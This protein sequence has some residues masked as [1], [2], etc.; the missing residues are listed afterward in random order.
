MP[1]V[2]PAVI[3]FAGAFLVADLATGLII[4]GLTLGLGFLS[5]AL[6]PKTKKSRS[7]P[8]S[9]TAR[10]RTTTIRS[11]VEHHR[12]I[13]GQSMVSG[14]II[15]AFSTGNKNEFLHLVIALSGHQVEEIGDIFFN[16]TLSTDSRFSGLQRVNKNLG[17]EEQAADADLLSEV[18]EW[19][20][21]HQL[22]GIAYI[23]VRL[24]WDQN[25]WVTGIPNI[26]AVVKGKKV[27]DTRV[28]T[29]AITSSSVAN[30]TVITTGAVHSLSVGDQVYITGHS[31]SVPTI[32][33]EYEVITV[34][35]TTTFTIRVNVTTG[36]TGGTMSKMAWTPNASLVALDY[37]TGPFGI[38]APSA[39]VDTTSWTAA[40]NVSEEQVTLAD[41]ADTF[42]ADPATEELTITN[43]TV[44]L[45]LGDIVQ[46]S[47]TDTLPA[48]LS[49][50]T[51]Y[52]V[53][54]VRRLTTTY[55]FQLAT[56]FADSITATAI[57]I[58]DTGTGTHTVTR[59]SQARYMADGVVFTDARPVDIMD[60]L[61]T[62]SAGVMVYQ[63][64]TYR[65]YA[66]SFVAASVTLDEDD[67]RRDLQVATK[68]SRQDTFNAVRGVFV[69]QL[70]FWQAKD[71]PPVTNSTYETEDGRR[72]FKDIE[73]PHTTDIVRAQR[74]AKIALER[75]RQPISVEYPGQL[76]LLELATWDTINLTI[77]KLGWASK[78][79]R[80]LTWGLGDDGGIDLTLQEEAST[81]YDWA[82]G[83]E[84][85][86]DPAPNTT[87]TNPFTVDAP[88]NVT[89]AS[90]SANFFIAIDGTLVHRIRVTWTLPTD[91]FVTNGGN[92]EIQF[93]KTA[94][95]NFEVR[96]LIP[97]DQNFDFIGPVR[98]GDQ[99]DIKVRFINALR[100]KSAFSSTIQHTVISKT[101]A[102]DDVTQFTA[103]QNAEVVNFRWAQVTNDDLAGYEIRF[104]I[105][106]QSTYFSAT[107]LTKVTRGTAVTNAMV[108]AGDWTFYIKAVDTTGNQSI[109]AASADAVI[110]STFTAISQQEQA[111]N[112]I[113]DFTIPLS[114]ADVAVLQLI[115]NGEVHTAIFDQ[116][117]LPVV[118][119]EN[120]DLVIT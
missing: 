58:T 40:A 28:A 84:T 82:G 10:D 65:G 68:R 46:V 96:P 108:P 41:D 110:T 17:S 72:L 62:A 113:S 97:G 1:P 111:P 57:N 66:G 7:A 107:P 76:S 15:A 33:G 5:Q 78:V 56:T 23:Y 73:L 70:D 80:V 120:S 14:P 118:V 60:D 103:G 115:E 88:T 100:V 77:D 63:Q 114:S 37:L 49:A 47:T 61:M 9:S 104:G 26:K 94:D 67:L 6:A 8:L 19:T 18:T 51:N 48:G 39:S 32:D 36:G 86:T 119:S 81:V 11:S 99:Y 90:G 55:V 92:A 95:S 42:T 12:L 98:D 13:Y 85:V 102:P 38:I 87:L 71:F 89:A 31:G 52:Y 25:V 20:A 83:E 16:D 91:Q 30:P 112:W 69:D 93:K 116:D 109:N 53:I 117:G 106:A 54:P 2:I 24:K 22:R 29:V 50:A 43:P 45:A 64:G 59:K 21:A 74:L 75:S 34:P 3:A 4:G 105:R 79:F 44:P 35:T 27:W 101:D